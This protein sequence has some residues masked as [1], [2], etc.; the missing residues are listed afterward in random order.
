VPVRTG[1]R[2]EGFVELVQGPPDGAMVVLSGSSFIVEGDVVRPVVAAADAS[3]PAARPA[4]QAAA[5]AQAPAPARA[6]APAR[7]AAR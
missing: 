1:R 6:A 5:P 2:A 4:T 3:R 7:S